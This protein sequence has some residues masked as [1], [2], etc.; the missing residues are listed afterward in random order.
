MRN[1][2]EYMTTLEYRLKAVSNEVAAFKN[3]E[4]YIQME[5]RYWGFI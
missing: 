5:K 2:F 3:G 4:K 1:S